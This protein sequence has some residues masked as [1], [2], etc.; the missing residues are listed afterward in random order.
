MKTYQLTVTE[1]EAALV[2]ASREIRARLA[3]ADN[4]T[5]RRIVRDSAA[6]GL[7]T[8]LEA[9]LS[10]KVTLVLSEDVVGFSDKQVSN[11]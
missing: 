6:S 2:F 5:M 1:I 9:L 10:C 4:P 11:V 7:C 3:Q 8:Q